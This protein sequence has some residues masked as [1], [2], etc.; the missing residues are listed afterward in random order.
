MFCLELHFK[1]YADASR[2]PAALVILQDFLLIHGLDVQAT[3]R[4]MNAVR[5]CAAS[6][7]LDR[8]DVDCGTDELRVSVHFSGEGSEDVIVPGIRC[9]CL[10]PR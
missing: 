4:A 5:D 9:A 6:R 10:P 2:L 1:G 7:A 3:E 8:I